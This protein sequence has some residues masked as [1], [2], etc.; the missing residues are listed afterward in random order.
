MAK[1]TPKVIKSGNNRE[2]TKNPTPAAEKSEPKAK[3]T[4]TQAKADRQLKIQIDAEAR[5]LIYDDPSLSMEEARSEIIA[6][7]YKLDE[8]VANEDDTAEA[9]EVAVDPTDITSADTGEARIADTTEFS[10]LENTGENVQT[11]TFDPTTI[12]GY[13]PEEGAPLG[14]PDKETY[15]YL[16][17]EERVA[18]LAD[19]RLAAGAEGGLDDQTTL[20]ADLRSTTPRPGRTP[21]RSIFSRRGQVAQSYV[22]T[23]DV[24]DEAA[25]GKMD[26]NRRGAAFAVGGTP[27]AEG[28]LGPRLT[29]PIYNDTDPRRSA[30]TR[31]PEEIVMDRK[32][33]TP[34][35]SLGG[36][37]ILG[38]RFRGRKGYNQT[39]GVVEVNEDNATRALIGNVDLAIQNAM[40]SVGAR[41]AGPRSSGADLTVEQAR[42]SPEL[43]G[44]LQQGSMQGVLST[45]TGDDVTQ[46]VGSFTTRDSSARTSGTMPAEEADAASRETTRVVPKIDASGNEMKDPRNADVTLTELAN[47][48]VA[49]RPAAFP[50][51]GFAIPSIFGSQQFRMT[52]EYLQARNDA[53]T[54]ARARATSGRV[55]DAD[56]AASPV[57]QEAAA[58]AEANEP[59]PHTMVPNPAFTP[60]DEQGMPYEEG[61]EADAERI[62]MAEA[63]A[64]GRRSTGRSFRVRK[65]G[66]TGESR[67]RDFV[68]TRT[69]GQD[70]YYPTKPEYKKVIRVAPGSATRQYAKDENGKTIL[71]ERG[72]PV[73]LRDAEGKPV[74]SAQETKTVDEPTGRRV[75]DYGPETAVGPDIVREAT[76]ALRESNGGMTEEQ[77]LEGATLFTAAEDEAQKSRESE[78]VHQGQ[79]A[80][81]SDHGEVSTTTGSG[82]NPLPKDVTARKALIPAT[83]GGTV[84]A[85]IIDPEKKVTKKVLDPT[86]GKMVNQE[87]SQLVEHVTAGV[88]DPEKKAR[89]AEGLLVKT[90]DTQ[91]TAPKEDEFGVEIEEEAETNPL[92]TGVDKT[93]ARGY[94]PTM[95]PHP[96]TGTPAPEFKDTGRP[97]RDKVQHEAAL[98][99]WSKY[100]TVDKSPEAIQQARDLQQASRI[101]ERDQRLAASGNSPEALQ[102]SNDA[103]AAD[104][105]AGIAASTP[106]AIAANAEAAKADAAKRKEQSD[107]TARRQRENPPLE[108]S[109]PPGTPSKEELAVA[110]KSGRSVE[111]VMAAP[112]AI[113]AKTA[114]EA[115]ERKANDPYDEANTP[116]LAIGGGSRIRNAVYPQTLPSGAAHPSAGQIVRTRNGAVVEHDVA[117]HTPRFDENGNFSHL[118]S[119]LPAY[120]QKV[121]PITL[122]RVSP[123]DRFRIETANKLLAK[124]GKPAIVATSANRGVLEPGVEDHGTTFGAIPGIVPPSPTVTRPVSTSVPGAGVSQRI[125]RDASGEIDRAASSGTVTSMDV[126]VANPRWHLGSQVRVG[127]PAVT[128]RGVSSPNAPITNQRQEALAQLRRRPGQP[129][130]GQPMPRRAQEGIIVQPSGYIHPALTRDAVARGANSGTTESR[131]AFL[132]ENPA[133]QGPGTYV[134]PDATAQPIN[135]NS[136]RVAERRFGPAMDR[137][138]EE[139]QARITSAMG[140]G[141]F[142]K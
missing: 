133:T 140:G 45:Q 5:D 25:Q 66:R 106:E 126:T 83:V 92:D 111:E 130:E 4:K 72:K 112:A 82:K 48:R 34:G 36:G 76:A 62:G 27:L 91:F 110:E 46:M 22:D 52:A 68:S 1:K 64:R 101:A 67:N 127:Q 30:T 54:A 58:R 15:A 77:A 16:S 40:S 28:E 118:E 102:R 26:S 124:E 142:N 20:P 121:E 59:L 84:Q 95:R 115:K 32:P 51:E 119:T 19:Q 123:E 11:E 55:K 49:P 13:T 2:N 6:R 44:A 125:V 116:T 113:A 86:T 128:T 47:P 9:R 74:V 88:A 71:D 35:R 53:E 79:T 94:S 33:G 10:D 63:M 61:P 131:P 31:T 75:A 81:I 136:R 114:A 105:A 137:T 21:R 141:Q 97:R 50:E 73:P 42:T 138:A 39:P 56:F 129:L 3:R 90:T 65:T 29:S 24:S 100:N 78:M 69:P 7:R 85:D 18:K 93:P 96:L 37:L 103:K 109:A 14:G 117:T 23:L 17:P 99:E 132:V 8:K 98:A 139:E 120:E 122:S 134:S 57:G 135:A 104:I 108:A 70:E 80:G 89:I 87:V 43:R 12:R 38:R 107:A 60:V 41:P